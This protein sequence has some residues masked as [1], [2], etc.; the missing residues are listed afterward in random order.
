M[1]QEIDGEGGDAARDLVE[2]DFASRGG[3]CRMVVIVSALLNS[4]AAS[5]ATAYLAANAHTADPNT[6]AVYCYTVAAAW[7]AAIVLAGALL[8]AVLVNATPK[9]IPAATSTGRS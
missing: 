4:I 2:A 8:V 1:A 3:R 7:G 9:P 5:A 6:V